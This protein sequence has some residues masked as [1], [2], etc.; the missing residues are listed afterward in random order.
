LKKILIANRGEIACRIART[1]RRLGIACAGIYSDHDREAL[2]VRSVD[3]AVCIGPSYLAIDKIIEAARRVGADGIHPGYGFL[4]ENADFAEACGAAAL[5]F[6]GPRAETIR[7]MSLKASGRAIAASCGV[8]V[9]PGYQGDDLAVGAEALGYPLMIKASAGGGGRRFGRSI[10]RCGKFGLRL[11][12][13]FIG[14]YRC[15]PWRRHVMNRG[16]GQLSDR[17]RRGVSRH[18]ANFLRQVRKR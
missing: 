16:I 17:A 14:Q 1:A 13:L 10:P 6:I 5:T 11:F 12:E 4:A 18:A 7:Q 3:E 2:H 15:R 8:P 9:V